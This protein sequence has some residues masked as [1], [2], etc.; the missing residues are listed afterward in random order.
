VWGGTGFVITKSSKFI[1]LAWD[2][3]HEAYMTK[4]N[5]LARYKAIKY[6]PH[7]Y[8]ALNDPEFVNVTDDFYGGQKLGEVWSQAAKEMPTY[9]Q[10]PVRGDLNTE[11]GT[12]MTNFYAGKVDAAGV[13]DAVMAKTKQAIEDL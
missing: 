1:D 6:L 13:L 11:L 12:Q 8:D 7:M 5:Q 4:A 9:Y 3:I 10:S 2:L